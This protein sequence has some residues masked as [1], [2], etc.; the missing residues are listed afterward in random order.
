MYFTDGFKRRVGNNPKPSA[1]L[2]LRHVLWLDNHYLSMYVGSTADTVKANIFRAALT[3]ILAVIGWLRAMETFGI[4]WGDI[5]IVEPPDGLTLGLPTGL[6]AILIRL[7]EQT[8]SNQHNAADLT[9]AYTTASGLSA[10]IWLNHLRLLLSRVA[11]SP[12]KYLFVK[13]DGTPW[14]SHLYHYRYLYPAL[15]VLQATGDPYLAKYADLA[16]IIAAFWSFNLHRRTGR[17]IV[18]KKRV[19]TIRAATA[20]ETIEHGRWC[21]THSSLDMPLAYLEWSHEDKICVTQLCM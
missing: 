1:V 16:A 15:A 8:K 7:L 11:T 9:L 12:E 18:S 10:G 4:R 21:M 17:P 6:G 20:A 14:T 5:R 19:V 3:N 13:A 2:L